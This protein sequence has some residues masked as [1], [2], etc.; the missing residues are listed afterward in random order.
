VTDRQI[1]RALDAGFA[2]VALD[3]AALANPKT[4]QSALAQALGAAAP[5]FTAHRSVV[6]HTARG[7]RDPRLTRTARV[8]KSQGLRSAATLGSA[9]GELLAAVLER[10]GWPRGVVTGGD[11][12]SFAARALGIEALEFAAPIAPGAPLCRVHAPGQVAHGREIVFKGGQ[13]G[14]DDFFLS[15][16][17]GYRSSTP[18]TSKQPVCPPKSSRRR[19]A[20]NNP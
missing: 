14:R 18:I 1:S 13:N 6:F 3:T 15:A 7:P 17:H 11:T 19:Q 10:T 12:S 2:E 5:H 8:L 9:L 16:L 20:V 4:R